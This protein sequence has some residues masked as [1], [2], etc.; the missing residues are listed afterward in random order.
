MNNEPPPPRKYKRYDPTFKRS[1]VELWL[2]G[3]KSADTVATELGISVQA[4][5]TWKQQLALPLPASGA[6]TV[7]E[8]Q[9]ENHRLLRARHGCAS[10]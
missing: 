3:G 5:K 9:A 8:L 1:A 7:E 10:R 6:Q 4:L 2:A